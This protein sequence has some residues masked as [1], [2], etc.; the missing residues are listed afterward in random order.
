MHSVVLE[1]GQCFLRVGFA[2]ESYPRY[3][4]KTDDLHCSYKELSGNGEEAPKFNEYLY[5]YE[6]M[7]AIFDERL[8]CRPR[9]CRVL[10]VESLLGP[11]KFRETLF[12]VMLAELQ[13]LHHCEA[14]YAQYSIFHNSASQLSCVFGFDYNHVCIRAYSRY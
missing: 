3:T 12:Q 14:P 13:V 1:V 10:V 2:G 11:K 7:Q 9:D 5:I 8:H 6:L 4:E